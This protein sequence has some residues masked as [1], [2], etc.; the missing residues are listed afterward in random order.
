M[1][2]STETNHK[3]ASQPVDGL[4]KRDSIFDEAQMENEN[5]ALANIDFGLIES[6]RWFLKVISGSNTGAEFSMHPSTSYVIGTDPATC[7]IVFHDSSVSRQHARLTV[8]PDETLTLEDLKSR[9][10]TMVDDD[11]LPVFSL[12][13]VD[14]SLC[15]FN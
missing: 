5:D 12:K 6:G 4:E 9:N 14:R 1:A 10:V 15:A 11:E 2:N 7:D 13:R 3:E 8:G